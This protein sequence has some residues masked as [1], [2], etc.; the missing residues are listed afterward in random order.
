[1][2]V[3]F[4]LS[5]AYP[6]HNATNGL[7]A[8]TRLELHK[9]APAGPTALFTTGPIDIAWPNAGDYAPTVGIIWWNYSENET[10]IP[11]VAVHVAPRTE[12]Q[13][14]YFNRVN[15][16]L[17]YALVAFGIIEIALS[18]SEYIEKYVESR[19]KSTVNNNCEQQGADHEQ[20]TED[21]KNPPI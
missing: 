6:I 11:Y 15:M 7:P 12:L 17:T 1:M 3:F 20:R 4:K 10:D 13:A 5:V 9:M 21:G 2:E 8:E 19:H 18:G 14:E 16:G